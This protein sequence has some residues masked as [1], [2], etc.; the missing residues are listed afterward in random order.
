MSLPVQDAPSSVPQYPATGGYPLGSTSPAGAASG[1][2]EMS[3]VRPV[4]ETAAQRE[5][6]SPAIRGLH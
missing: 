2:G 1:A 3:A 5:Y 4:Y 6:A